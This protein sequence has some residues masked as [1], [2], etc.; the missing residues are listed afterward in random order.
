[1]SRGHARKAV[2]RVAPAADLSAFLKNLD[3]EVRIIEPLGGTPIACRDVR[4]LCAQAHAADSFAAC[5]LT[6]TGASCPAIRLGADLAWMPVDDQVAL[7]WAPVGTDPSRAG[8]PASEREEAL[9]AQLA[10]RWRASSDVAQV[11]ANYLRC[12]PRVEAVR[13]PG[14]TDDPSFEVAARTLEGGFGPR[15]DYRLKGEGEWRALT[16]SPSED[17]LEKVMELERSLA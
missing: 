15:V 17:P 6:L 13:Y 4:S 16:C 2:L 3:V 7:V 9:L 14:L 1:M 5:D 12:H 10:E 8:R 11:V